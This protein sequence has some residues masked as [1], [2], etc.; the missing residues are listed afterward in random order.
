MVDASGAMSTGGAIAMQVIHFTEGASD[1][2]DGIVPNTLVL[3]HSPL[4]EGEA[5]LRCLH[6]APGAPTNNPPA[7]L[8]YAHLVGHCQILVIQDPGGRANLLC[9]MGMIIKATVPCRLE[10][11]RGAIVLAVGSQRPE[12]TARG[13]SIPERI[14]GQHW[15]GQELY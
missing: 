2:F 8:D 4:G 1:W 11:E 6:L 14:A 15:P 13:I 12:P 10:C 5:H 7:T 3:Y 9:G